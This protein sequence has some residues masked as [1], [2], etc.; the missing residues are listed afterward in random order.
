MYTPV[1]LI[2]KKE[3]DFVGI[4][5]FL[6]ESIIFYWIEYIPGALSFE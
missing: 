6:G 4:P 3:L 2:L 1:W 5:G